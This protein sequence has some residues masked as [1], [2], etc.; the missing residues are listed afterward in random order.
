M[1]MYKVLN[2]VIENMTAPGEMFEVGEG[3]LG[4]ESFKVWANAPGTMRD[5]WLSTSQFAERDYLV[6]GEERL[7]YADAHD[8]V[9]RVAHW[10][11]NQGI[12]RGDR[13]A[14]AMRNYPEWMLAYWAITCIG[15]VP[16]G[17]NAWW[18]AEELKYGLADSNTRLLF[19]DLERLARF[20]EIR[21]EFSNV[22]VVGIR[23]PESRAGVADWDEVLQT[24]PF[25]PEVAIQPSDDACIFYTSGTTGRP[26]GAQLTHYGCS[27]NVF[28]ML[29]GNAS[30]QVAGAI[31][32]G[33][34]PVNPFAEDAPIK[35][36]ILATPLFHVTANNCV[37]QSL[38]AVGGKLVHTYK[39]DAAQALQIVQ[40]EAITNFSGV[41]TM[42]REMI[43]HPDF[44]KYDT[45]SL[46][47]LG[48]GGAPVQPDLVEKIDKVGNGIAAAQG[49]GLTEV[50]GIFAGS[51][52]IYLSDKPASAGRFAPIFDVKC[53]DA[54]G[55]DL[56]RGEVGEICIRGVQVIKGYLNRPE[57]TAETIVDG[58]LHTGDIGY[59][60]EDNFVFLVDRAKDMVLRGGEN[61][62][63]SEVEFALYKHPDVSEC[64]V[65][66]VDDERLGEEVGAAIVLS[67]ESELSADQLRVFCSEKLAAFKIPRYIW[68]L[69]N[70]LPRTA[71]GKFVKR[72][73]R[74]RLK[75][76][77]AA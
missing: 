11:H 45:S 71:T 3:T 8:R 46:A 1:S 67:Q 59:V 41:P 40:D 2:Q 18:V 64:A 53:I 25:L 30:Q 17:I 43:S 31:A 23:L 38:T 57:A 10:M 15:A 7:S 73:L 77:D 4:D 70:P 76:E 61:V 68:L 12:T 20:E 74:E 47:I 65:F 27:N 56:P 29:F 50:A 66:P 69:D 51:V 48:G 36:G 62:Y 60:D 72:S 32:K 21:A 19:C 13:V 55:V 9:A 6:Y 35:A 42:G 49:Y 33:E 75:T 37:A 44:A 22:G 58:W 24:E 39:W 26:K 63:S 52:G 28:S 54:S 16:V 14:I 34:E 5:I